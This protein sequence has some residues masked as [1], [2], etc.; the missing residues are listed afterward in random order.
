MLARL[1]IGTRLTLMVILTVL[2][3]FAASGIGLL[4]LRSELYA[5]RQH[6]LRNII[7]AAVSVAR[8]DMKAAGGAE[9]E[10][11]RKAFLSALGAV[12]FGAA[13]DANYILAYDYTGTTLVHANPKNIGVNRIAVKDPAGIEFVRLFLSIAQSPA[14]TGFAGYSAEKGA[15]GVVLPKLTVIQNLPE[16]GG[17][18]GLGA[19]VED[20]DEVFIERCEEVLGLALVLSIAVTLLAFG[21]RR[22]IVRP[23]AEIT[24]KM[25]RLAEGD[26]GIAV[27]GTEVQTELGALARAL[28]VFRANAV[29]RAAA[30]EREHREEAQRAERAERITRLAHGFDAHVGQ[31]LSTLDGSIDELEDSSR[32]LATSAEATTMRS[33][34]VAAAAEQAAANVQTAAAATEELFASVSAIRDRVAEFSRLSGEA[35]DQATSAGR[36]I[37]GLEAATNRIGEVLSLISDIAGQ[38]NLL[39]LNATIEAARA[40]EAGRG[41]AVV[42]AEVKGLASQ[43]ARATEEIAS[44]INGVQS[45]ARQAVEVIRAIS[46]TVDRVGSIATEIASDVEQQNDATAE[47]ARN[48]QEAAAGTTEVSQSIDGVLKAAAQTSDTSTRLAGAANSLRGEANSLRGVVERFLDEVRAAG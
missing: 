44:Q 32:A 31:T 14:G 38:T 7:D 2:G 47:I 4:A 11:G 10:A 39:A 42:A 33:A 23:V 6:E 8:A 29:D 21:I 43:T 17:F 20:I 36:Q 13:G 9:S 35:T 24:D 27:D 16:V 41:F 12:R 45:E 46:E 3:I 22:S 48:S 18:A 40:G 19:Y 37:A 30:Y 26:T 25:G 5:G 34:T 28:E 1:T 15:G